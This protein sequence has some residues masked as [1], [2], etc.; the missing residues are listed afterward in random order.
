MEVEWATRAGPRHPARRRHV[1]VQP[2]QRRGRPRHADHARHPRRGAPVEHAAA[3]LHRPGAGLRAAGVR[4]RAVRRRAGQ[5]EQAEQAQDRPVPEE[6]RLQEG[7]RARPGHRRGHRPA[8]LGR[9]VQPGDRRFLPRGRLPAR[10][11]PQLPGAARLVARRQD[12]VLHAAGDDRPVLAGARQQ[13]AGQLRPEEAVA[14]Q[15][16]YMQQV[17]LE[18][19]VDDGAAVPAEGRAGRRPTPP[20]E[21]RRR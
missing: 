2:G 18:Q 21:A 17:P 12:G 20:A 6:P 4:P 15:E 5:Q 19:K 1:P 13:G 7:V 9:H 10:R 3:D 11:D 8:H 16:R 14:F